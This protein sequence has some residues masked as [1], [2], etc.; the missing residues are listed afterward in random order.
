M[1]E[2]GNVSSF[3]AARGDLH[4]NRRIYEPSSLPDMSRGQAPGHVR[5]GRA[6][7]ASASARA[8]GRNGRRRGASGAAGLERLPPE[9]AAKPPPVLPLLGAQPRVPAH[10]ECPQLPLELPK[11]R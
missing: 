2:Q 7:G 3:P 10:L 1:S 11:A 8:P 9:A 6:F 4:R 5:S